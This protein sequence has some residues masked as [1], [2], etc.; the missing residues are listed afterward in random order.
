MTKLE[1]ARELFQNATDC[2]AQARAYEADC[3]RDGDL[4]LANLNKQDAELC[5]VEAEM[6]QDLIARYESTEEETI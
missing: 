4:V 2:A 6:F 1:R 3:R 5:E